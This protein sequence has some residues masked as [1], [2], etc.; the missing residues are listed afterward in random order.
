MGPSF[1][2]CGVLAVDDEANN[3]GEV[4]TVDAKVEIVVAVKTVEL[5]GVEDVEERNTR[6]TSLFAFCWLTN[7][8][9]A[10]KSLTV[11]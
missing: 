10:C 1:K 9:N 5:M 7:V 11:S 4:T 3:E 6:S 2:K 8:N